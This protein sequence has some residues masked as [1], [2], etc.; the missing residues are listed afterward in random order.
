M[1]LIQNGVQIFDVNYNGVS[2]SQIN[3]N[4][5]DVW[6]KVNPLPTALLREGS[7]LQTVSQGTRTPADK[8]QNY[9]YVNSNKLIPGR[10]YGFILA[11]S[12]QSI[13][14]RDFFYEDSSVERVSCRAYD[15]SPYH[16]FHNFTIQKFLD[17]KNGIRSNPEVSYYGAFVYKPDYITAPNQ[18]SY[19]EV[20]FNY[21]S[22]ASD[23]GKGSAELFV[24]PIEYLADL[25]TLLGFPV[26]RFY[27]NEW[28]EESISYESTYSNNFINTEVITVPTSTNTISAVFSDG[29]GNYPYNIIE[30]LDNGNGTK[31][32]TY[33]WTSRNLP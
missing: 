9:V 10:R 22:G 8:L 17:Y 14:H 24:Y 29:G 13:G 7:I 6:Y 23:P 5:V 20:I 2:L 30:E 26:R 25:C 11:T 21:T 1:S 33:E 16:V 31:T 18:K 19:G 12:G 15:N 3:H 28:K 27:D 32:I 4:G